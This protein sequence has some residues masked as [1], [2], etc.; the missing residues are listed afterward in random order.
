MLAE[1]FFHH[2]RKA[3]DRYGNI[4]FADRVIDIVFATITGIFFFPAG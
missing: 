4:V 2:F 3:S 1:D